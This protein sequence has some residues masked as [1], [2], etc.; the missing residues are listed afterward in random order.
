MDAL[1]REIAAALA[2][3]PS[4]EFVARMR[5]RIAN[6]PSPSSWRVRGLL[7]AAG[8]AVVVIAA[9]VMQVPAPSAPP[10]LV[11]AQ[12]FT[13]AVLPE[14]AVVDLVPAITR[15]IRR[16]VRR[17]SNQI[18]LVSINDMPTAPMGSVVP[19]MAFD[20]VTMTGVHP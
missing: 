4:P 6:E 19:Q 16:R 7:M 17:S 15:P 1:D 20:V 11:A 3:D 5:A 12:A 2:V 14:P 18:Q 8:V 13:P 10:A 9:A